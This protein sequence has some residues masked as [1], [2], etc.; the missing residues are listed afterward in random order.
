M[1]LRVFSSVI[2]RWL[3]PRT[4][5]SGR[6]LFSK[7]FYQRED[8]SPDE[9]FYQV[10]R[11]VRHIDDEA[12]EALKAFYDQLL[13]ENAALLDLMSS[14][15]SH[16]PENRKW[17]MVSGLGMNEEEL[18]NN[19]VLSDFQVRNLNIVPKLPYAEH[20]F[21][22]CLIAV[23]VQYLTQPVAVFKEI[24]R[25]LVP[26]GLCCVS[27]SNRLFPTKAIRAWRTSGDAG[28][29]GLVTSYFAESHGFEKPEFKD[30][31]PYPGRT[32]PLYVVVARAKTRHQ[33]E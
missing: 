27:F 7:E 24:A 5:S 12:C 18:R 30:L 8:E 6:S 3:F 29:V 9:R 21:D 19:P 4:G 13:P 22:A 26:D 25:V 33:E 32:D 31:S 10:P 16:L 23:S 15:V 20:T 28:H 14:W 1:R 17:K 2:K 11:F